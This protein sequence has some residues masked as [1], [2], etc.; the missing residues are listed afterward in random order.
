MARARD[1][2]P[3]PFD[4]QERRG[5]DVVGR[6]ERLQ[7]NE[8]D[9]R[10]A[11]RRDRGDPARDAH[12]GDLAA[13]PARGAVRAGT[14]GRAAA[15][16]ARRLRR[17]ARLGAQPAARRA[18]RRATTSAAASPCS[19]STSSRTPTRSRPRSPCSS[20]ATTTQAT[21]LL[22]LTPRPG[23]LTV[24]GDP[25]QSIYRFRRADIAVYD[26]VRNGPLAGGDPQLVQNFRSTTA[27]STG[28]TTSSTACS[29]T[30]PGVQPA[31][32]PLVST[33]SGLVDESPLDLRRPRRARRLGRRGA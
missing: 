30:S 6:R 10:R 14:G 2:L 28:S 33:G 5:A 1:P 22:E 7:A 29:S 3:A 27:S 12:G 17:P 9:L 21:D 8:G 4:Q 32:T 26:A 11:P 25:K 23:G 18:P 13:P 15:R 19:S 24:V 31:N 20:P 16:G